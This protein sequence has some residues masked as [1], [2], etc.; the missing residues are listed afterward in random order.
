MTFS[1]WLSLL[2]GWGGFYPNSDLKSVDWKVL[3]DGE[4]W[5]GCSR[6]PDITW[7]RSVAV[8]EGSQSQLSDLLH[9]FEN[10]PQVFKRVYRTKV[11]EP[12]VVHVLIDMPFPF[13]LRDYI[14]RFEETREGEDLVFTFNAVE[15]AEAAVPAGD[16]VRLPRASGRWRLEALGERQTRVTYTWNGE[17]LGNLPSFGLPEAWRTQGAEVMRWLQEAVSTP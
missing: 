10:Y 3:V 1:V 14:A 17:L 8:I 6:Q 11:L 15:H 13:K 9:D 5:V 4:T 2:L 7:C 16:S 12:N